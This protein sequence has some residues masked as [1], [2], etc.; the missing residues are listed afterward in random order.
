MSARD[1]LTML[2]LGKTAPRAADAILAAGY[3]KPRQIS[4]LHELAAVP[5]GA[6]LRDSLGQVWFKRAHSK[7]DSTDGLT[8]PEP[9]LL[10][11]TVLYEPVAS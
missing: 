1:E 2:I 4:Y 7:Y 11:A 5:N 6:V 10:P 3:R 9:T 8:C